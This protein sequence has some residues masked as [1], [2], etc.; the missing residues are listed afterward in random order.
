MTYNLNEEGYRIGAVSRM[1]GIALPTL[2]MWERRY[3]VVTPMRTPA[4]GRIYNREHVARLALLQTAV[5]AG[6]QIGGAS[7]RCAAAGPYSGKRGRSERGTAV[8]HCSHRPL[9]ADPDVECRGRR[10]HDRAR[11]QSR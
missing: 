4:G 6:H 8:P 5:Q 10:P 11:G 9:T 2:R 3:K 1:T 7:Q